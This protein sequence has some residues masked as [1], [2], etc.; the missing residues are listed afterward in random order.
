VTRSR[1]TV[2]HARVS[3]DSGAPLLASCWGAALLGYASGGALVYDLFMNA[4]YLGII[5]YYIWSVTL[6]FSAQ[7]IK[8]A[9]SL[10]G[11]PDALT[12]ANCFYTLRQK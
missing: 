4:V 7:V 1:R 6:V 11:S 8:V 3:I 5:F 2:L 10:M 9:L 12:W